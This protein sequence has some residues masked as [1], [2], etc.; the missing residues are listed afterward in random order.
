MSRLLAILIACTLAGCGSPD[1]DQAR[2]RTLEAEVTKLKSELDEAK[3][4]ADRL[5]AR[6]KVALEASNEAESRAALEELLRRY[7]GSPQ[8]VDGAALLKTV[9]QRLAKREEEKRRELARKKEEERLAL[10][11]P[12]EI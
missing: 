11:R 8:S 5:L 4:G 1:H 10:E 12:Q 7:P 2:I 9:N 6:G 3:F